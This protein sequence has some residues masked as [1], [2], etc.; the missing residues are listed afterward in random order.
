MKKL[1]HPNVVHLVEVIDS[2]AYRSLYLVME[3]VS[4][5][6]VMH[7]DGEEG[8]Y[9]SPQTGGSLDAGT[10]A[11]YFLDILDGLE[12]LHMHHIA[13]RDLKPEVS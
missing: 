12:Y 4:R 1:V 9:V 13:H 2:P 5:G 11:K 7:Q 10:A 3:Y 8:R 6:P